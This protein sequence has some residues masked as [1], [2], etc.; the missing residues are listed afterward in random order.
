LV[1]PYGQTNAPEDLVMKDPDSLITMIAS[2]TK[3]CKGF[4][5]QDTYSQMFLQVLLGFDQEPDFILSNAKAVLKSLKAGL[6]FRPLQMANTKTLGWLFGL[7]ENTDI[8]FLTKFLEDQ[9]KSRTT[10]PTLLLLGLKY[11]S[12]WDG[13][14]KSDQKSPG[15]RAV[16]INCVQDEEALIMPLL[17]AVLKSPAMLQLSNLP[18]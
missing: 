12:V 15:V 8:R 3:Y 5:I 7:H 11:K 1:F 4:F 9:M 18:L 2:L 16:H 10:H 13:T 6:Y 17:K 14:N